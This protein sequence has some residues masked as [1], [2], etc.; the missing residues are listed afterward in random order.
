M[1]LALV[2]ALFSLSILGKSQGVVINEVFAG[3]PA[4][5]NDMSPQ[6]TTNANSLYNTASNIPV[7]YNREFIELY[8]SNPC[9]T[10]DLSCYT[11]G[12]NASSS[13][14]GS[15][16]GAFTFPAGTKIPP[17]GFI[18]VGGNDSPAPLID[19]NITNYRQTTFNIQYLCGDNERWFLRDQWGWIALYNPQG[20]PVDA[21]Y[22]NASPGT[23]ASLF[24]ADE[25]TNSILNT[26]ACGGSMVLPAANSIAGIEY[27]GNI[28]PGSMTSFQRQQDGSQIW[29][30][31]PV[32]VTPRG[33][34]GAPIQPA[35]LSFQTL[36]DYCMNGT[37]K[38]TLTVIPGGTGPYTIY[39]NGSAQAG[40]NILQNLT[41]GTY[42]VKVVDAYNCL[43]TYDTITVP[44][45]PGPS[46]S[47][48]QVENEKCSAGNGKATV[49][50]IGG[51]A[52]FQYIWN[53][54]PALN[55]ATV[56]TLTAGTWVV[57][58]KDQ[59]N[60]EVTDSVVIENHKE[61]A[62]NI[63]LLSP[64]SCGIGRGA[65]MAVVSGDYPPYTFQWNTTPVQTD[66]VATSLFSGTYTVSVTDGI[67]TSTASV[68]IPLIPGPVADFRATP[69][70]VYIEDGIVNFI[71]LS[72]GPLTGWHWDFKDGNT[73]TQ[74]NPVHKF[75][76]LGTFP[77]TLTVT[78]MI[79]CEGQISHPVLVKDITAAF[80]PN[81]F[82]PDGDGLN[83]FFMPRGIYITEYSL[84]VFD[85]FGRAVF[86]STDPLS[87]W[88]GTI[89]GSNAAEGVYAWK[90]EFNFDYGADVVKK[91]NLSGTVT[92]LRK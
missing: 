3:P 43:I 22:W 26:T 28:N 62:V 61:P 88:D 7:P 40:G 18:L 45:A 59:N 14:N 21:V 86:Y 52:P 64:D 48:S 16:W 73:S 81:A 55:T 36:P 4:N 68:V 85:R 25:Y 41:S 75:T 91:L 47:F 60:C 29:Y 87:G 12:S 56:T 50:V 78:D 10:L 92:L 44:S 83:D 89:E 67:C 82:T 57:H 2:I 27:V 74:Q 79:G 58:V 30:T 38:I 13:N 84:M 77:V 35:T 71:D 46:L 76:S 20:T 70:A 31:T 63:Q 90:A 8:N 72:P 69:P 34:N 32:P 6:P 39:W 17:L 33:P 23:A 49:Q 53:N 19:F 54:N 51:T 9:D 65:A 42:T 66:S 11:L 1:R 80:F 15:N 37:G 5:P 24:T